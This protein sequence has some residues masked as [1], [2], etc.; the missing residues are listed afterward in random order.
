MLKKIS[1]LVSLALLSAVLLAGCASTSSKEIPPEP[2]VAATT[3]PQQNGESAPKPQTT[4]KDGVI[5]I[6][7]KTL[8]SAAKDYNKGQPEKFEA[9]VGK[10]LRFEGKV[11]MVDRDTLA[12]YLQPKGASAL[13]GAVQVVVPH[14]SFEKKIGREAMSIVEGSMVT[15]EGVLRPKEGRNMVWGA[16]YSNTICSLTLTKLN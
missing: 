9:L 14:S 6:D 4:T 8:I 13:S 15:V 3:I 16:S 5:D 11:V 7:L 1:L 2:R 12:T 10:T